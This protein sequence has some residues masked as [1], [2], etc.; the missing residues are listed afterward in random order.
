MQRLL[1]KY[2]HQVR[3]QARPHRERTARDV[4]YQLLLASLNVGWHWSEIIAGPDGVPCD[5]R[6]VDCNER[7]QELFGLRRE[8]MVGRAHKDIW[9]TAD[10]IWFDLAL[11]VS[12]T[13]KPTRIEQA[14]VATNAYWDCHIYSPAYMTI[15]VF[16]QDISE[17]VR[18]QQAIVALNQALGARAT[19]LESVVQE[20]DAF[21]H[22][23]T[24]DL[25][26]P[27][28]YIG[29]FTDLL[30]RE[31]GPE[32]S[33]KGRHYLDILRQSTL[34][35]SQ[36]IEQLLDLSRSGRAPMKQEAVRLDGLVAGVWADL[37]PDREGRDIR[38]EAAPLPMVTG[39]EVLLR[40]VLVNL[41]SNAIKY[42]QPMAVARIEVGCLDGEGE[43]TV[44]VRDNGMG[45][46][47]N[48]SHKLFKVFQRLH[49]DS[50]IQGTGIGLAT[51]QRIIQRHGGR[52]WAEG[53]PDWGA[54]FY[55]ALPKS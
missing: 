37:A 36:L 30:E 41:L 18:T 46:D 23:V 42:T 9:P 20:L 49:P 40:N 50:R 8:D 48:L 22:T 34:N 32:V 7:C 33:D 15:A 54:T 6:M 25:R 3:R 53:A 26:A 19:E 16:Y 21:T 4:T 17:R 38:W 39:D 55:F 13:G 44:F 31:L 43:V 12:R 10:P 45:F 2:Y 1:R 29:G 47:P 27:I 52:V 35:M 28:R 5:M 14:S 11:E 51:V 24:H